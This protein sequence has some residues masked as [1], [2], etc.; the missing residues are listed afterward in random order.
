MDW[1]WEREKTGYKRSVPD[2][3]DR[4]WEKENI[5]RNNQ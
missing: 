2:F 4:S 1:V 3:L 5:W